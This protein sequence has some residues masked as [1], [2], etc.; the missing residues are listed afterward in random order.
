MIHAKHTR[1]TRFYRIYE[2][3]T[4]CSFVESNRTLYDVVSLLSQL[5]KCVCN[6]VIKR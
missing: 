2:S 5:I 6:F 1:S 3:Q 4:A